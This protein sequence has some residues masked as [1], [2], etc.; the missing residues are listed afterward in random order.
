YLAGQFIAFRRI[1]PNDVV[2]AVEA[3]GAGSFAAIGVSA[4][5]FSLA[6]L[7]NDLPLGNYSGAID[8]SGTIALISF[9]VGVEVMAAFVLIV[10]E[11]LEQ[12]L[13]IRA[14]SQG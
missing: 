6:F 2:E 5:G 8:S 13:V 14:G 3:V 9:F 4:L 11:L 12:T 10:A 7:T 1:S